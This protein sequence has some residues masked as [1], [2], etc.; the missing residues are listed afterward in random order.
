MLPFAQHLHSTPKQACSMTQEPEAGNLEPETDMGEMGKDFP[1]WA[2][3]E[4]LKTAE[5]A[6]A[7]TDKSR[8]SLTKTATS[9]IGWALPL[10]VVMGGVVFAPTLG[11]PRRIAAACGFILTAAA[12][13]EAFQALRVRNWSNG[14]LSPSIW[15][16]L[17]ES[18]PPDASAL[19]ITV[20]RLKSLENALHINDTLVDICAKHVRRAWN[21]LLVMPIVAF[22]AA[23]VAAIYL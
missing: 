18:P 10:S 14:G 3:K 15:L 16:K 21:L 1:Y 7:E 17:I 12:V 9:I 22:I 23:I 11:M 4:A 19:Y 5:T 2:A 13:I 6:L 20:E 8:E